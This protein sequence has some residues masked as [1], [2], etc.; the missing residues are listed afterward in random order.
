MVAVIFVT[1]G[2][3]LSPEEYSINCWPVQ[4]CGAVGVDSIMVMPELCA[5]GRQR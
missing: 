4:L 1:V 3:N 5:S 2:L